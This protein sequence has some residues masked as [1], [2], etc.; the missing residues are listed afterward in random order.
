MNQAL[1][2][3]IA[4]CLA[5]FIILPTFANTAQAEP[6]SLASNNEDNQKIDNYNSKDEP[7]IDDLLGPEDNFPF[8]TENH[9]DNSNPIA[10]IG[11]ILGEP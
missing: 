4:A 7:S 8:L 6:T 10:R 5:L 1:R 2:R 3:V 9:R 11:K